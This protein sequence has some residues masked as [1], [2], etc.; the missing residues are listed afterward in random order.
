MPTVSAIFWESFFRMFITSKFGQ[1]IYVPE[2]KSQLH[3]STEPFSETSSRSKISVD[4]LPGIW[5]S[6]QDW[7][8]SH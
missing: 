8:R 6:R 5:K 4:F 7:R 2:Q 3:V 1:V